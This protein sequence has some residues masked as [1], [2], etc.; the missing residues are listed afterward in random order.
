MTAIDILLVKIINSKS[1]DLKKVLPKKDFKVLSNLSKSVLLPS[2]ITYSQ[3]RL[4]LK[5][6][7]LHSKKM[8]EFIEEIEESLQN[9]SWSH[10][11][12]ETEEMK[13]VYAH[14]NHENSSSIIVETH[15]SSEIKKSL[16]ELEEEISLQQSFN[17]PKCYISPLTELNLVAI[18]EK[19]TPHNFLISEELENYYK[20][21]KSWSKKEIISQFELENITNSNLLNQLSDDLSGNFDDPMLL[22]DRSLRYGYVPPSFE[23]NSENL[24]NILVNRQKTTVWVDKKKFMLEQIFSSL[25][26]LKRFPVMLIFDAHD[27]AKCLTD[28]GN[29]SKILEKNEIFDN[30]GIYFRLINDPIGTEFN[31]IVGEKKYNS[32][33]DEKIKVVGIQNGKIPKFFIKTQW[34]PAS[35]VMLS[36]YLKNS[37]TAVF[38]DNCDLIIVHTDNEPFDHT[39]VLKWL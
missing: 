26:Q 4:L 21:I 1:E 15:Y 8:P 28:L 33:L 18:V 27:Q 6:L 31:K 5:L 24:T 34:K 22:I 2:F 7:A 35:I 37:K 19:L 12:R 25:K 11:F 23:E 29:L 17:K 32:Y 20:I 30:V 13:K 36:S 9:P 3:S 10:V 16:K 38:A 39:R 14:H